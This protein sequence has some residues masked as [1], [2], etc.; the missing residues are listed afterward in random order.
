MT[1]EEEEDGEEEEEE[2]E[3]KEELKDLEEEDED[4]N[5]RL[6]KGSDA[7]KRWAIYFEDLLNVKE[8]REA[9]IVAVGGVEVPVM[10][11]VKEK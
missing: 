5:G 1:V 9:D 7:R 3:E 4:E 10:G 6:V 11:E 2:M 8:E